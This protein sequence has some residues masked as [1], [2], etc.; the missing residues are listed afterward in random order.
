MMWIRDHI[1]TFRCLGDECPDHCCG[2][3]QVPVSSQDRVRLQKHMGAEAD[4][5]LV[6]RQENWIMKPAGIACAAQCKEGLCTVQKRF[7]HDALPLICASYPRS[8][9]CLGKTEEVGGF[10]SCPE[11]ARLVMTRPDPQSK[12]LLPYDDRVAVDFTNSDSQRPYHAEFDRVRRDIVSAI[13]QPRF[14]MGL[15]QVG[16]MVEL[17]RHF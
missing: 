16:V 7:G 10:L 15:Y 8:R 9:S 1:Q 14:F 4:H 3:W 2:G 12:T 13:Y 17:S 6:R 5:I 11:N